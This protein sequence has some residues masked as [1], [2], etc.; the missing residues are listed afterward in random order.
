MGTTAAEG[1]VD[2]EAQVFG[3]PGLHVLDGAIIPGAVGVNPSHT[4][5]AVAE[6]SIEAAIRRLPGRERWTAPEAAQAPRLSPPEDQI[7]IPAGGTAPL[8]VTSG[9]VRWHE[10]LEGTVRDSTTARPAS[11]EVTISVPDVRSFVTDPA[12]PGAASGTVHVEGLTD[13]AGAPIEAGSFHLFVDEGD[14]RARTMTYVLPFC[15]SDGSRWVLRGTKD[16]R[17]RKIA[18]F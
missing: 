9:G 14:P 13:P 1:V 4:I 5:A 15:G 17:G 7:R 8:S 16:V 3:Y 2:G 10:R 6:R 12:H 11:F 18:D